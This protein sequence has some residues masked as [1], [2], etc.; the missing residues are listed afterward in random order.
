MKSPYFT[1]TSEHITS[2]YLP[3]PLPLQ[4]IANCEVQSASNYM[5]IKLWLTDGNT[6]GIPTKRFMQ[7]FR[8]QPGKNTVLIHLPAPYLYRDGDK[9]ELEALAMWNLLGQYIESS[10]ARAMLQQ[11]EREI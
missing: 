3:N 1:L 8:Y 10:R 2:R 4:R 6:Y 7:V 11:I 5:T 9:V